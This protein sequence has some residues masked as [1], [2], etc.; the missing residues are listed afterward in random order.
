VGINSTLKSSTPPQE[1]WLQPDST[2]HEPT[3]VQVWSFH[4]GEDGVT[5]SGS[6]CGPGRTGSTR[7]PVSFHLSLLDPVQDESGLILL[8]NKDEK[9]SFDHSRSLHNV[10]S[11]GRLDFVVT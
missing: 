6:G 8:D 7:V 4:D 10:Q 2:T 5:P 11:L 1:Q 3:T 9:G